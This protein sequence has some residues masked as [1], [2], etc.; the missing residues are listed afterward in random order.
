[1]A[2]DLDPERLSHQAF[3]WRH[4]PR[5]GPELQLRVAGR[6]QLQQVV[7][8]AIVQLETGDG[9]RVT[10][11]EAFCQP[12]DCGERSYV[13]ARPPRE[14]GEAVVLPLG[15]RLAMITGDQGDRL[16]FIGLETAEVAVLHQIV[17]VLVMSFVAD[18]NTDVVQD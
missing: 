2:A 18:V 4:M 9:L 17:R 3:E 13:P 14:V 5:G 16:D 1:M 12:Q 8:A 6:A 10:T 7:V 11:I 15:R